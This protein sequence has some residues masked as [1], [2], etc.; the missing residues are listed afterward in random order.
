MANCTMDEV[1]YETLM[2][3]MNDPDDHD[4]IDALAEDLKN[5][6]VGGHIDVAYTDGMDTS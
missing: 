4:T 6:G 2:I 5:T 3:T 1:Y